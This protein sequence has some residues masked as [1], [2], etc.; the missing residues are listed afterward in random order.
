MHGERLRL[1]VSDP[2]FWNLSNYRDISAVHIFFVLVIHG[3]RFSGSIT[4]HNLNL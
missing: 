2:H 1:Y 4:D 3:S